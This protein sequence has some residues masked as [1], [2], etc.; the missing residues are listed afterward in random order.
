MTMQSLG[1]VALLCIA[2]EMFPQHA[3]AQ[4]REHLSQKQLR[5][6]MQAAGN[7]DE[8]QELASYFRYRELMFRV[9]AQRALDK[10]ALDRG[11]SAWATKVVTRAEVVDRVREY[12]L[13]KADENAKLAERY[14]ARLTELGVKPLIESA[15]I[16]S[17][18]NWGGVSADVTTEKRRPSTDVPGFF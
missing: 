8:Y 1:L 14:F 18:K 3:R 15:T 16:V 10:F 11:G 5:L 17:A 12:Y 6:M 13:S 7:A 9:K 4:E 2:I